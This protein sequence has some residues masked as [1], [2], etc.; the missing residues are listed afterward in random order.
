MRASL[1]YKFIN[2]ILF[3]MKKLFS[4]FAAA[5]FAITMSAK[6]VTLDPSTQTAVDGGQEGVAV[7]L[8]IDGIDVA[9]T[10]GLGVPE[11]GPADFRVFGGKTI[12][13][14]AEDKI[15]KIVIAGKA[16]KAN[17]TASV[18]HGEVTTGASYSSVTTKATL[19]DPLIV[20]ENIDSKS[21]TLTAGKQLR[22]YLIQVTLEDSEP[23][24]LEDGFYVIVNDGELS[25]A[26]MFVENPEV[27]GEYMLNITLHEGDKLRGV[28]LSGGLEIPVPDATTVYDI[29]A[30]YAGDCI[31]Y[32]RPAGNPAWEWNYVYIQ[33]VYADGFYLVGDF[34]DW[35]VDPDYMFVPNNA[36]TGEEYMLRM[37]F[38]EGNDG[39]VK[40]IKAQNNELTW[41]PDGD[42]LYIEE[43]GDLTIYFREQGN[44]EW[45]L[46][47][48]Y[49]E[50]APEFITP[51]QAQQLAFSGNTDEY[52]IQ[53]YVTSFVETW[54]SEYGNI[55][56][57]MADEPGGEEVFEAFRLVCA[58]DE[59]PAVGDYVWVQASLK[60]YTNKDN[61]T[62][63][64]TDNKKEQSFGIISHIEPVIPVEDGFYIAGN[65]ND[66]DLNFKPSGK[67]DLNLGRP[68][69]AEYMQ[70]M[71]F[72]SPDEFQ[73]ELKVVEFKDG[74]AVAWYPDGDVNMTP[75]NYGDVTVY[76]RPSGNMDWEQNYI[77]ME[78][79][80]EH[81][82]LVGNFTDWEVD[83]DYEL[84]LNDGA[85]VEEWML[86]MFMTDETEFKV[87]GVLGDQVIWF[88]EGE[89][90]NLRPDNTGDVDIYFRPYGNLDWPNIFAYVA[91]HADVLTCAQVEDLAQNIAEPTA[92]NNKTTNGDIVT[93]RGYVTFAYDPKDNAPVRKA[94]L[95][96]VWLSDDPS[97][98]SGTV[99]VY[100]A[101]IESVLQKG[102]FVEATGTL[103]RFWKGEGN[104]IIEITDG[105]MK[106]IGG[107]GG[108]TIDIIATGCQIS[109]GLNETPAWWQILH[110]G[111]DYQV[112]ICFNSDV[113]DGTYGVADLDLD[114]TGIYDVV[115]DK[116]IAI[117]DADL[118]A[119]AISETASIHVVG[120]LIGD[121]GNTY[122]VDL[123]FT[124]P[125]PATI[126][127]LTID[128]AVLEDYTAEDG[129]IFISGEKEQDGVQYGLYLLLYTDA[130]EGSYTLDDMDWDY[131]GLLV[132]GAPAALYSGEFDVHANTDVSYIV[133]VGIVT[134]DNIAYQITLNVSNPITG[135]E[136]TELINK[137]I[138]AIRNG[139]LIINMNGQEFNANGT[140]IK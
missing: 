47:Y 2:L 121:D 124:T 63:A 98:T 114:Y 139:Q 84:V 107:G 68:E 21:V 23:E 103:C 109:D 131:S 32:L 65:F 34:T 69:V 26:N 110:Y 37:L 80:P 52:K 81:Y 22:A 120:S 101:S 82:Y 87:V 78:P 12:T 14:T 58:E 113:I 102:D 96:S 106:K 134:Y 70:R 13:L 44:T 40:V 66:W 33:K 38:M 118:T 128:D 62:I 100:L 46:F 61:V 56:F 90:N 126:V 130:V 95:Q 73:Y 10:G 60:T 29:T 111:E 105:S 76:F 1:I 27:K 137:V 24:V 19:D 116:E 49:V 11:S 51:S 115:A 83:E 122:N 136:N 17:F 140:R 6:V 71:Y 57:W 93:V 132:D 89:E 35:Q 5:L 72:V 79:A 88:P 43:R 138:K 30:E 25:A 86:R 94:Q 16:N 39:Y 36:A 50:V 85:D 54:K 4:I 48:I 64:E 3:Q 123:T 125:V 112:Y 55:S 117:V 75:D 8:S 77:H 59:V 104:I 20:V 67:M 119:T 9:Y 99:Q 53:G 45:P 31:I 129:Y 42:N 15:Q 18:D 41:I 133:T 108:E 91:E 74:E 7:S 92:D 28:M 135:I 97:A 127:S